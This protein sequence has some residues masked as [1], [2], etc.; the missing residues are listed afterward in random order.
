MRRSAIAGWYSPIGD[1]LAAQATAGQRRVE[2]PFAQIE[3]TII[4]SP[5]PSA[6]RRSPNWWHDLG[7]SPQTWYGWLRAG[8][9][10]TAPG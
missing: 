3:V 7:K 9:F 5:L 6:A 4:G 8:G 10:V 1:Y 2:L